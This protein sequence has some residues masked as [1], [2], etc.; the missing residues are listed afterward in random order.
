MNNAIQ[1]ISPVELDVRDLA[2]AGINGAVFGI[3][4]PIVLKNLGV[5]IGISGF[6]FLLAFS[7][8]AVLGVF[9]GYV[10]SRIARFF[11]QLTKFG[12]VGAANTAIDFGILNLLI[13]TT[14]VATGGLF[15]VFKFVSFLGATINSYIWNKYWSFGDK[16]KDDIKEEFTKFI[17]ISGIGVF[18]NVGIASFVNN[19]IGPAAGIGENQWANIAAA[20]A[21]ISV[22]TWNFVG[23]KF[24]V[25]KK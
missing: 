16:S 19:I 24:V 15:I 11:F 13:A 10:L 9:V 20:I 5:D 25:F 2:F 12:S 17:T 6:M 7:I 8:L 22:L 21:A 14:G 3:L 4:L 18:L 1:R 23:Y